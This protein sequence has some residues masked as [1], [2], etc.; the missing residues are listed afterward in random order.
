M[1]IFKWRKFLIFTGDIFLFYLALVSALLIRH[2]D[3][4]GADFL[5][6]HIGAFSCYLPVWAAVFYSLDYN[7]IRRLNKLT[8]LIN[9]MAL[10]FAL[11]LALSFTFFYLFSLYF[12]I[13]PKTHLFLAMLFFHAYTALWRRVWTKQVFPK[14]LSLRVAFI[15][16]N[17]I[18]E[19]IK[20]D[21]QEHPHYGF[22]LA[23]LHGLN[24]QQALDGGYWA[25]RGRR[26][27]AVREFDLLVIAAEAI[28][29]NKELD[30]VLLAT[31]AMEEVPVITHLDFYEDL[32]GKI[33][34]EHAAK[35]SWLLGNAINKN[36]RFYGKVKRVLDIA[37]ASVVFALAFPFMALTYLA[38]LLEG[39]GRVPVFFF[40]KR[41]G[42]LG[43]RFILWKFRTMVPGAH[44]AGPFSGG[45][46]DMRV[47]R[48]GRFLRKTRLDELPQLWNILKGD[49]SIVGPRPEWIQEV[50]ILECRVPHYHLRHLVKPGA[51]GWAQVNFSATSSEMQSLEKLHYDLYYVKNM[52]LA[53]DLGIILRTFRRVFQED[54]SFL[55]DP[56]VKAGAAALGSA[57]SGI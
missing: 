44:K 11:N 2:F 5:Y 50:K 55:A 12:G 17:P 54:A 14:M 8:T 42:Y 33:P 49:M 7:D 45:L 52:S 23:H 28:D 25:P 56:G 4:V 46:G 38:I 22:T 51:T 24:F 34:P 21:L 18:I 53:L 19:K 13:T 15:G 31:A 57:P 10:G 26:S 30:K 29:R 35:L 6:S 3:H 9:R 39:R 41:V 40:Q 48:L 36:N 37:L 27:T 47:T 20:L 1:F 16:N 32:Y 43:R